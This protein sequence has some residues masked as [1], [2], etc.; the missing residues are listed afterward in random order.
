MGTLAPWIPG[1]TDLWHHP[2]TDA[3]MV[4]LDE[5][6]SQ[7]VGHLMG[8][9]FFAVSYTPD[10]NLSRYTPQRIARYC[11]YEG[12]AESF[13]AALVN[14]GDGGPGFLDR[15]ETGYLVHDWDDYAGLLND[16]RERNKEHMRAARARARG[17]NVYT[18]VEHADTREATCRATVPNLTYRTVPNHT[19]T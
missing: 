18:R 15:C 1:Y 9:W 17:D 19:H 14:C 7:C 11:D 4:L 13:C 10:G 16:R 12:D 8:L 3:L 6:R 2:K 5:S